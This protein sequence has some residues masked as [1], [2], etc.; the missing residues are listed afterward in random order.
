MGNKLNNLQKK[1]IVDANIFINYIRDDTIELTTEFA[2]FIINKI[3]EGNFYAFIPD[4]A[5]HEVMYNL[6][7]N[8]SR[9][10]FETTSNYFLEFLK[11]KNLILYKLDC[12]EFDEITKLALDY[13]LS[14][15]DA[16]YFYLSIIL[17]FPLITMD[18]PFYKRIIK[19]YPDTILIG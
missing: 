14:I 18:K 5:F 16:S 8:S 13:N 17:S 9:K 12:K 1:C 10:V 6:K 19:D 15:Y 2:D 3:E 7:K 11:N 4:I